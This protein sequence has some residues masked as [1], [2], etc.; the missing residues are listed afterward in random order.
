MISSPVR[1]AAVV[2]LLALPWPALAWDLDCKFSAD[3][4]GRLDTAGA[5]RVEIF[6]R[7]GDLTVQPATGAAVS[8]SGRAC[9]SSQAFLDETR[10]HVR[11]EGE[12]IRVVVQVPENMVG[13]GLMY[14]SLDLAVQVPAS[15]PVSVT[16]SSGDMTLEGVR[17][18]RVQDS[19]GD[20]VARGLLA[21]LEVE[22]SSGDIRIEDVQG[23]V[24]V[25]DSSGDL[26][27]RGARGV[28]I[29]SDSSGDIRIERIAGNVTIDQDSSGDIEV[30]GVD[31]N[32][33]LRAD[34]S[35]QVRVT[36][37]KGTT[38]LP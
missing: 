36:A 14:A 4:Q 25:N 27:I 9:A 29:P 33:T 5:S 24:R 34:G 26:T 30:S 1:L 18:V 3:R 19:S 7:A 32:F 22:D 21:D 35:G 38:S 11:R 37:V 15:L 13:I 28:H 17:V 20:I 10:L 16:D 8:A 6:A 2:T 31:G 23:Q 12:V